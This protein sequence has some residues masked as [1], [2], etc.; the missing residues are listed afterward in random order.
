MKTRSFAVS[1]IEAVNLEVNCWDWCSD[2]RVIEV[3]E[4]QT[5]FVDGSCTV[6]DG[7]KC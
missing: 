5:L 1:I 2:S 7:W 6:T 3:A 4:N